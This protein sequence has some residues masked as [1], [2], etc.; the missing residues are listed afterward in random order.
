[1]RYG[2]III[3]SF[4]SCLA[5]AQ[6]LD[7]R[8]ADELLAQ[9]FVFV[10]A[11]SDSARSAALIAKAGLYTSAGKYENALTELERAAQFQIGREAER[12]YAQMLNYFLLGRFGQSLGII[13]SPEELLQIGR[14]REYYDMHFISLCEEKRWVQCKEELKSYCSICDS[15]EMDRIRKLPENINYVDPMKCSLLSG[16]VPGLGMAK[17]GKPFKGATSLVIQSG[18]V[19]GTAYCFYS[20]YWVTGIASGVFPLMKF[21]KGGKRLSAILAEDHND[22]EELK[23]KLLYEAEIKKVVYR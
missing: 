10:T 7:L 23:L 21:H 5:E 20:G 14:S 8:L 15:A 12:R 22:R 1:M 16:I 18:L 11:S 13:L 9:E 19:L 6:K 3:L 4:L 17:A 2:I